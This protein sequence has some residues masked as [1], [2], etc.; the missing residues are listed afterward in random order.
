ME[1]YKAA[2]EA[3]DPSMFAALFLA[4]GRY[5]NTPFQVQTGRHELA[6]Y[7]KRIQLQ[8]DILLNFEVLS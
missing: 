3:R 7:W 8:E 4:D 2:W 6:E 5:H 1:G